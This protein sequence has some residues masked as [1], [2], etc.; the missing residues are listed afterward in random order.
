MT[1]KESSVITFFYFPLTKI[2]IGGRKIDYYSDGS[3]TITF[4]GIKKII[5]KIK[6]LAS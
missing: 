3:K 2:R 1:T 4:Y 5:N 6:T